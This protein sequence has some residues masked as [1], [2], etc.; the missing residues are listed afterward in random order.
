M[1]ELIPDTTLL[2]AI[3]QD[4]ILADWQQ[5]SR[6]VV[7]GMVLSLD[8]A[9]A[10]GCIVFC[11]RTEPKR[12]I[13]AT[14]ILLSEG[15]STTHAVSRNWPPPAPAPPPPQA[16]SGGLDRPSQVRSEGPLFPAPDMP[17]PTLEPTRLQPDL[18][19]PIHTPGPS[20][21]PGGVPGGAEGSVPGGKLGGVSGGV[22]GGRGKAESTTPPNSDAAYLR[23][24]RPAYPAMS[25]KAQ[26]S[27]TVLLRVF[28][29]SD[30]HVRHLEVKTSSG[31]PRLDEAALAAVKRWVFQPGR[32]GPNAVDAW[33]LVPITF[34]LND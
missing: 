24:P 10:S 31:F 7:V 12:D 25:R 30:G 20:G 6:K 34:S 2:D 23:N 21:V 9:V 8:L 28:V 27:G 18:A 26:E 11:T 15:P 16:V 3:Y 17:L 32:Q 29:G 22:L 33:V 5:P 19:G 4:R 1:P 13:R 14:V